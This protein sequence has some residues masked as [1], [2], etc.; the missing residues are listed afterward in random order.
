MLKIINQ[1]LKSKKYY[2]NYVIG[3]Y[4][5]YAFYNNCDLNFVKIVMKIYKY[6]IVLL[7]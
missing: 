7:F 1:L 5:I 2:N 4:N 3:K 6:F